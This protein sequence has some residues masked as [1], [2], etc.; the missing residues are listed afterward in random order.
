[1][2]YHMRFFDLSA[3]PIGL[4]AIETALRV[5]DPAYSLEELAD[6]AGAQAKFRLGERSLG[7][8]AIRTPG[9]GIF[10]TI[11]HERKASLAKSEDEYREAVEHTLAAATRLIEVRLDEPLEEEFEISLAAVDPLWD[12][13]FDSREGLLHAEGE[14]FYQDGELLLDEEEL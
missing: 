4:A 12:W 11:I 8:L 6:S 3:K 10:E 7:G 1:M 2:A 9:D 13:L 5:S 14:G